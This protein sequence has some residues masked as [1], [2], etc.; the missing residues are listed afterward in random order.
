LAV[1]ALVL[2]NTCAALGD[3]G[4][5]SVSGGSR[6]QAESCRPDSLSL[7]PPAFPLGSPLAQRQFLRTALYECAYR[8]R[9][10]RVRNVGN[11]SS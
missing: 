2:L 8:D 9:E 7:R 1:V 11:N 10:L 5:A 6:N 4:E 3:S